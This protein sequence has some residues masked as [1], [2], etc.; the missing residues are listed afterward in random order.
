MLTSFQKK[1]VR[2]LK[3]KDFQKVCSIHAETNLISKFARYGLSTDAMILF[4]TNTPCY[5]CAKNLIQAGVT[6]I[7]YIAEHTDTTGVDILRSNGVE[8]KQIS[9]N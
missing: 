5:I 6:E 8:L 3:G 4:I 1:D 2:N 7:Y 9:F